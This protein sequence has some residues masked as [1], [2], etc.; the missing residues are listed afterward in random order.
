M[1]KKAWRDLISKKKESM[2]WSEWELLSS[3]ITSKTVLLPEWNRAENV[4][5][6]YSVEKEVDTKGILKNGWSSGKNMFLPKSEPTSKKL[7]FFEVNDYEQLRIGAFGIH[8]PIPKKCRKIDKEDLDLV[9]VPGVV[10]DTRGYRIG[11]GGG[12]YDRFLENNKGHH[13]P[14]LSLAFSFQVIDVHL[15]IDRFDIPVDQ[16][17]TEE[18]LIACT[19]CRRDV[20]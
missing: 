20:T 17:I 18:K 15:P 10:F 19:E 11:Y 9:I 14:T 3:S 6:Y 13:I 7:T 16:I 8:E 12:F 4:A 5:L 1:H 2:N